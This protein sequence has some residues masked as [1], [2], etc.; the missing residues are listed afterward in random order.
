MK[1]TIDPSIKHARSPIRWVERPCGYKPCL[2]LSLDS[3]ILRLVDA[4][5]TTP[6]VVTS[7]TVSFEILG[8]LDSSKLRADLV[9]GAD[10]KNMIDEVRC[11][12]LIDRGV[13]TSCRRLSDALE[14]LYSY[15]P[16]ALCGSALTPYDSW[17]YA[18]DP[19]GRG[20]HT[21][22][23]LA[24]PTIGLVSEAKRQNPRLA[25]YGLDELLETDRTPITAQ[26]GLAM[27]DADYQFTRG[28]WISAV[29]QS[30][31]A[32]VDQSID[33]STRRGLFPEDSF[34]NYIFLAGH[35][36]SIKLDLITGIDVQSVTAG[37]E[38][39]DNFRE[40]VTKRGV[41]L[42]RALEKLCAQV[43]RRFCE[44][45]QKS[46]PTRIMRK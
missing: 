18:I 15:G 5:I 33:R 8:Q 7:E 30:L 32:Q 44:I 16:F 1:L 19:D 43:E 26:I 31:V 29:V 39:L 28:E 46:G 25:T 3:A 6:F 9:D 35:L 36:Y 27:T 38:D 10:L 24:F 17:I 4:R 45:E 21:G 42:E 2:E 23:L 14:A 13:L 34:R 20:D 41:L 11:G 40:E 22:T 12:A 37:R